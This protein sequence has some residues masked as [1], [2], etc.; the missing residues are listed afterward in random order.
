MPWTLTKEWILAASIRRWN[1]M[2]NG[3]RKYKLIH[4]SLG[5]RR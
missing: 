1:A 4:E 3:D 5:G 2:C